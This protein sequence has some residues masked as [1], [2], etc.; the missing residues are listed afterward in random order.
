MKDNDLKTY[1]SQKSIKQEK[2]D[3]AS[4]FSGQESKE[5]VVE[6]PQEEIVSKDS[7]QLEEKPVTEVVNP[8]PESNIPSTSASEPVDKVSNTDN[9][10]TIENTDNKVESDNSK[11]ETAQQ[12]ISEVKEVKDKDVQDIDIKPIEFEQVETPKEKPKKVKKE[13]VKK[14]KKPKE[15]NKPSIFTK[16]LIIIAIIGG[17]GYL[18][19]VGYNF[20]QNINISSPKEELFIKLKTN[21]VEL[22]YSDDI[23]WFDYVS[24]SS[25]GG[26]ITYSN[27]KRK[28]GKQTVIYTLTKDENKTTTELEVNFIDN[29]APEFN[30]TE[31]EINL[32]REELEEFDCS[33]YLDLNSIKDNYNDFSELNIQLACPDISTIDEESEHIAIQYSVKDTSGNEATKTLKINITD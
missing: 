8:V 13:K 15:S 26:M 32:T 25:D 3:L 12:E 33:N 7:T 1:Y 18:G 23:N 31:D 27:V 6:T 11:L 21:Q 28:L 20:L 10:P 30:L 19:Y 17:L 4:F 5:E 16:I 29:E 2:G 9:A 24:S 14:I 22:N